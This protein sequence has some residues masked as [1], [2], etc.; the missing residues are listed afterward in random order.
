MIGKRYWIWIWY[1]ILAIGVIG[2]LAAIDWGRQIK[3]RNLDEILHRHFVDDGLW[4]D[5]KHHR[6][7]SILFFHAFLGFPEGHI[8]NQYLVW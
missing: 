4:V 8:A 7:F 3:W 6:A 5:F 2:L 1:A